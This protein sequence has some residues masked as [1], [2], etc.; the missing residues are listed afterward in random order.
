V[1]QGGDDVTQQPRDL[2]ATWLRRELEGDDAAAQRALGLLLRMVRVHGPTAGFAD[3]VLAAVRRR[4]VLDR[5]VAHRWGRALLVA[6]LV[7]SGMALTSA[8]AAVWALVRTL[9][10]AAAVDLA[11]ELTTGLAAAFD[12]GLAVWGVLADVGR[13]LGLALSAP[14]L[15][16]PLLGGGL[17]AL[18]A[19]R[20]L[21]HAASSH[22]S[23]IHADTVRT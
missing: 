11:V 7:S 15:V 8:P 4:P 2:V 22:W 20:V 18:F 23:P 6:S 17:L 1:R 5:F 13:A 12:F 19:L 3:R 9:D 16:V 14:E 21:L 10:F